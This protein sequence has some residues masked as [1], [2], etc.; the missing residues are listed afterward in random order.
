[1]NLDELKWSH[2]CGCGDT[3][4]KRAEV[5]LSGGNA[6]RI[7]STAEGYLVQR[8]GPQGALNKDESGAPIYEPIS[9]ADLVA[10]LAAG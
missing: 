10:L 4:D 7:K 8:F 1:M 3:P 5:K 9:E 2:P 6:L